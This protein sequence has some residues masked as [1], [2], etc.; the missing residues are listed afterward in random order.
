MD[1]FFI[2]QPP[3]THSRT[4]SPLVKFINKGLGF[5]KWAERLQPMPNSHVDMC[6]IEQRI[7][8]F[9][10]LTNT[11]AN[12]VA[13][14]VIEL[15]CFTGQCA[16]LF[17]KI[18]QENNADK[19]LH[20]YDNFESKFTISGSVEA[21]LKQNFIDAQLALP[22][23]H[24]GYFSDTIPGELPESISFVHVDCG[25]G[26]SPEE[27]KKIL[28]YCLQFVYPRMSEGA[29]CVLMDYHEKSTANA[30]INHNPGVNMATDEFFAD[31]PEKII[32]LYGNQY[33]HAYFTK[34]G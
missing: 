7:N 28:L 13:G 18:I 19:Q 14:D 3:F 6:T 27:H 22:V 33:S 20:L 16:M 15:G 34:L 4:A 17:Q 23:I 1:N 25:L 10:L 12:N 21:I 9:H 2:S 5:L 32:S 11:I 30:G 26:G 31:L 24:K 8:Y 29:I